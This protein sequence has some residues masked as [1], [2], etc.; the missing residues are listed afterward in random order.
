ML[1][2]PTYLTI[3]LPGWYLNFSIK[4]KKMYYW[5][6]EI[7]N[8]EINRILWKIKQNSFSMS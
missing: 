3:T 7:Q 6:T 2:S 5:E 1:K 4:F 8:Y